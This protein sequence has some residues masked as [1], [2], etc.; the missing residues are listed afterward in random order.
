MHSALYLSCEKRII[1]AY[2]ACVKTHRLNYTSQND[3]LF[4]G[5]QFFDK[6]NV[7]ING[8]RYIMCCS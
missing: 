4:L 5:N 3:P 1:V 7:R 8:R 2:F 6:I